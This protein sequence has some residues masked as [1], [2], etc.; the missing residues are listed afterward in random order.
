MKILIIVSSTYLGNTMKVAK[1]MAQELNATIQSPKAAAASD[2]SS[3]DLI[4][5]GSGICF[6]SHNKDIIS[7]VENVSLKGKKVFIFSTRCR[8]ILGG[9]HKKLKSLINEK[10]GILLGEFSCVGFDRTGP[11]V[12]MNGYNKNR[13]NSKDL[14]KAK[15]FALGMRKKAHPLINIKKTC[16][17]L[18]RFERLSLRNDGANNIVGDIVLLNTTTCIMCGKCIKNCPLNVFTKKDDINAILPTGEM[19]CIMCGKCEKQCPAD[20][21][22]INE[23]FRN[24]LR[25]LLRESSCDKLQKAYWGNSFSNYK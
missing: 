19:N 11:W 4:G 12:G 5:L 7:F 23:S 17:S 24:G 16:V 18:S 2:I 8:P 22:F 1:A 20:A 3:Y 6:A 21:I 9:Y 10:D 13:P 15:L 25:I 14:F